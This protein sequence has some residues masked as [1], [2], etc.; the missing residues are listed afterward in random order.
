VSPVAVH[1]VL[2]LGQIC[3]ASLPV[4]GRLAMTGRGLPAAGIVLVR[5]VGGGIVFALIAWRRG[6]LRVERRDL[7]ALVGCALIGVAANQELF[8]QGLARSTATNASVLGSTIPV[9]TALAAIVLGREPPSA[10]RIVG[11]AIAFA[12]AAVLVGADRVSLEPEH[13]VGSAMVL[14]NS[15]CYGTYLVVVRPLAARYDPLALLALM[16]A[17]GAPMVAP[18][19]IAAWID[20]PPLDAGDIAFLAFLVAVPTVAAYTLVQTALRYAESTLVAAY[21]YLQPVIA[22]IGAIVLLDETV[23]WGTLVGAPIVLAGVWLAARPRR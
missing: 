19:G 22:M 20:A 1:V 14:V 10:R 13:L 16:F 4:A 21:I 9:F 18:L 6:V 3:F 8:V 12:G 5:V 15:A 7:A 23:T 11:I 17:A 2:I